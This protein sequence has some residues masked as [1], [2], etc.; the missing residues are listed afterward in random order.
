[1]EPGA[2]TRVQVHVRR[3]TSLPWKKETCKPGIHLGP[4]VETLRVFSLSKYTIHKSGIH[5]KLEKIEVK[6]K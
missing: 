2:S 1:M 3:R 4:A 5:T 6:F